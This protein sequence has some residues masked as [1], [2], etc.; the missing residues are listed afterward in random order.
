[1]SISS[2]VTP[3]FTISPALSRTWQD[4]GTCQHQKAAAC[5]FCHALCAR[6]A[7]RAPAVGGELKSQGTSA[8][9]LHA[10]RIF[11]SCATLWIWYSSASKSTNINGE[12]RVQQRNQQF[13]GLKV[14]RHSKHAS[15]VPARETSL[16][17]PTIPPWQLATVSIWWTWDVLRHCPQWA[18]LHG[19]WPCTTLSAAMWTGMK[20]GSTYAVRPLCIVKS[21]L[22]VAHRALLPKP[23]DMSS[24]P[25]HDKQLSGRGKKCASAFPGLSGDGGLAALSTPSCKSSPR[26]RR[27]RH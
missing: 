27:P 26:P 14:N 15:F 19:T 17:P 25:K 2:V 9:S 18:D 24:S 4:S 16:L 13:P 1:M 10:A 22:P 6:S 5:I 3:G 12:V 11:L 7:Y 23:C 8:A 21:V 20:Q